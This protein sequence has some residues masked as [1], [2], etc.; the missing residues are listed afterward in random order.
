MNR[1]VSVTVVAV[2]AITLAGCGPA[3]TAPPAPSTP[4]APTAAP[5]PT[6]TPTPASA[7]PRDLSDPQLGITFTD[8]P[9]DQDESTAAAIETYMLFETAFWRASTTNVVPPGPWAT[10]SDE[11]IAWIQAQIDGNLASQTMADG[12]LST[13]IVWSSGDAASAV[14]DVCR[15]LGEIVFVNA[16]G[17]IQTAAEAGIPTTASVRVAMVVAP[18]TGWKVGTVENTGAC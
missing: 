2:C 8:F 16:D 13:A 7:G 6:P 17:T 15:T 4:P 12:A 11:A 1:L 5:T 14:L 10:A 18:V 3:D 9:H